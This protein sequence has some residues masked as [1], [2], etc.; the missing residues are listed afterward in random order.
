MSLREVVV[1]AEKVSKTYRLYKKPFDRVKESLGFSQKIYHKKFYALNNVS[2]ELRRGEALGVIGRNGNGKSTLLK[3]IAKVISPS[4]GK[5]KTYG[6]VSAILELTSNLK[7]EMTGRENIVYNLKVQGFTSKKEILDKTKEIEDFAE[8]GEFIDQPVK[9]YSSGMKSRLGFGI[10]TSVEPDILILDEVL[11]V[12]DF[13]FQQKCLAKINGMRENI[14]M[15]FVSHSMNSVRLFCDRV[16]VLEKGNLTFN[17]KPDDAIK[18]YLEQEEN[19]KT[20][21]KEKSISTKPFYGDLFH[22]ANKIQTI[23]FSWV[24]SS[25][26]TLEKVKTNQKVSLIIMFNLLYEPK[27]LI[28]GIPFWTENGECITGISNEMQKYKPIIK[29]GICEII[30]TFNNIFNP[31]RYI[32]IISI[33]DGSECLTRTLNN[34]LISINTDTRYFGF[35]TVEHTWLPKKNINKDILI[36]DVSLTVNSLDKSA[37]TYGGKTSYEE[38]NSELYSDIQKYFN[39]SVIFDI[40]ANYGFTSIVF[41][42]A[43]PKAEI[44]LVEASSDLCNYINKNLSCNINNTYTLH[45]AICAENFDEKRKF[46][47][48]PSGSQDNR[49]VAENDRWGQEVIPTISLDKL[50]EMYH[51]DFYFIKID[52]QGYEENVF[53]GGENYLVKNNNWLIKTEFAPYWLRSQGTNPHEFLKELISKYNVVELPMRNKFKN[54]SLNDI[55]RNTIQLEEVDMFISYIIGHNQNDRGW[56]DLMVYPKGIV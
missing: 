38:L 1:Y 8:I 15:I 13:N 22:N 2:L 41:A 16:I 32:S 4:S 24:D 26:N 5:V 33:Y 3:I 54:D 44:V 11:A 43:F 36:N 25:G 34:D 47:L 56:C 37:L 9:V 17:G 39:P 7:P 14:S 51:S 19:K 48:N 42:K 21:M 29:N 40:G 46:S 49:V 6:K 53:H 52:T 10:A 12:G 20:K 55:L 31:G 23:T 35:V 27:N 30:C 50:F 28:V 45:N 18:Y